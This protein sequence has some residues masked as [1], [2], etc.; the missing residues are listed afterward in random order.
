MR[1]WHGDATPDRHQPGRRIPVMGSQNHIQSP[2]APSEGTQLARPLSRPSRPFC[3]Q[4]GH[5]DSVAGGG[6]PDFARRTW[7]GEEAHASKYFA[8]APISWMPGLIFGSFIGILGNLAG[9]EPVAVGCIIAGA[10]A[11]PAMFV[12]GGCAA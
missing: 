7:R 4:P 8:T 2:R 1:A 10:V 6:R 5:E 11:F 12:Y 9:G 3:L